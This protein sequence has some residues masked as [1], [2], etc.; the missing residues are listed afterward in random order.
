[1]AVEDDPRVVSYA[2]GEWA[3][4]QDRAASVLSDLEGFIDSSPEYAHEIARSDQRNAPL[5]AQGYGDE[6]IAYTETG[7]IS[8]V[9][10][11]ARYQFQDQDEGYRREIRV[12]RDGIGR[13]VGDRYVYDV[14]SA[15]LQILRY[16]VE[17]QEKPEIDLRCLTEEELADKAAGVPP[18]KPFD[19][20]EHV[21]R[22]EA[23]LRELF[24]PS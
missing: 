2:D 10:G 16:S 8:L 1:M 18:K 15:W 6:H 13:R 24:S 3:R 22:S 21:V 5:R 9:R 12:Q 7:P 23:F 17:G 20:R 11:Q 14:S 4:L 19:F